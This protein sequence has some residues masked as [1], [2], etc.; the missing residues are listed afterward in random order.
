[1][2]IMTLEPRLRAND[3]FNSLKRE[4]EQE[5]RKIEISKNEVLEDLIKKFE[6]VLADKHLGNLFCEDAYKEIY[7]RLGTYCSE[8]IEKFSLTLAGYQDEKQFQLKAGI[9]LSALANRSKDYRVILH[10]NHLI[11]PP[12]Y[13]GF[14][15][16]NNIAIE[17]S[18][19]MLSAALMNGGE[20]II[21]G[22]A[23]YCIGHVMSGGKIIV[24]GNAGHNIGERMNGG[25]IHLQSQYKSICSM[26]DGGSI[27]LQKRLIIKNGKVIPG[28]NVKWL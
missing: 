5:D 3:L 18:V 17:G 4:E 23:G 9:F 8:N 26:L 20:M 6:N 12:P 22:N 13:I 24:K 28:S 16:T 15:N 2:A 10:T 25:E 1:M 11:D 19:G 7:P 14:A 21:N 27:Y